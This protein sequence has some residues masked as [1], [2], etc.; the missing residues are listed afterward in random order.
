MLGRMGKAGK[1]LKTVMQNYGISQGKLAAAMGI[2]ASNVYRWANE[3]R[4]PGSETV[5][6]ILEAL[7]KLNSDAA[8]EFRRLY[9]SN[10]LEEDD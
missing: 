7:E 6:K 8:T 10:E 4:D 5:M 2:G 1:V 3:I 9:M